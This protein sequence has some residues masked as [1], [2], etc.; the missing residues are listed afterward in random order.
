[1]TNHRHAR[2]NPKCT[3]CDPTEPRNDRPT[4]FLP[5]PPRKTWLLWL[6]DGMKVST[7]HRAAAGQRVA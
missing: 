7:R 1:M 4:S 6:R 3:G 5:Q 2:I